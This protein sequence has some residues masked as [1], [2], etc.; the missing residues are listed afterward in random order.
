M[1]ARVYPGKGKPA[2]K[3]GQSVS[4]EDVIAH[5]E[6]SAGQRLIKIA[7][8]LGVPG[9]DVVWYLTRKIGERIYQGEVVARKKSLLGLKKTEVKSPVD[10]LITDI[11]SRG[12][13]ILKFLP[14]PVRLVAGAR[15]KVVK[16]E[17]HK[18]AIETLATKFSGFVAVGKEREGM[19]SVISG[20]KDFILPATIRGDCTG[21]ILVGGA[22]LDRSALEKAITLGVRGIITGGMHHRDFEAL[23]SG[24]VGVDLM[25]TEGFGICPMGKEA[26]EFFKKNEGKNAFIFG[27]ENKLILPDSSGTEGRAA[28]EEATWRVLQVGDKVRFFREENSDLSGVVKALPGEQILNSGVLAQVA[29]V[30]FGSGEEMTIPAANLEIVE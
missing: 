25:I 1:L 28:S 15:G 26:W 19:I 21:K 8:A 13:L 4:A 22:L 23:G 2:V 27:K 20:A 16:L 10:G 14:T 7:H 30:T 3:E 11:D 29:Q 9:K 17:E 5:C 6:V 18:I 12:D 24:D